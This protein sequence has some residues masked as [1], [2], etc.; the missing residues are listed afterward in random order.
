MTIFLYVDFFS[1]FRPFSFVLPFAVGF[2]R[3]TLELSSVS[4]ELLQMIAQY[5]AQSSLVSHH[6]CKNHLAGSVF[7]VGK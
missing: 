2:V 5:N 3:Q 4:S 1:F 7:G 6:R